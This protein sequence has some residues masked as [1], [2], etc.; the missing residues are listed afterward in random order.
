[1]PRVVVC[2]AMDTTINA[3]TASRSRT[4][5]KESNSVKVALVPWEDLDQEEDEIID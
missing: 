3:I 1:M 2:L 4:N 5:L